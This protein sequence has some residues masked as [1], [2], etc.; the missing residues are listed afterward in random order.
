MSNDTAGPK[1]TRRR[2]FKLFVRG[3][4]MSC[5]AT[6]GGLAYATTIEP[7]RIRNREVAIR[8][9]G[10]PAAFDSY[11]IAHISDIHMDTWMDAAR[12]LAIA[13][14]VNAVG[15]DAIVI[16]G[17]FVSI[18]QRAKDG[19]GRHV[20]DVLTK[21]APGLREGLQLLKANDGV[22]A[23]PGNHDH[24]TDIEAVN[25]II[26]ASGVTL[27]TNG[28]APIRRGNERLWLCGVDDVWAGKPDLPGV[29]AQ[30]K[31]EA[32]EGELAI[33]LAHEPDSADDTA[34]TSRFALQ[35]SGH[36][37]GGQVA[38]PFVGPMVLPPFGRKYHTGLYRV[39]AGSQQMWQFT[40]RGVGMVEPRVRFNCPPEIAVL[41]LSREN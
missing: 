9:K 3:G 37:H 31:R 26:K 30:L 11:R 25:T 24:W 28:V 23:V 29:V 5:V 7:G 13:E 39:G 20:G 19:Q 18:D 32:K 33:L 34:A 15:A 4:V 6:G 1:M 8:L 17:D 10:L 12:F 2:F 16:T 38:L 41:T 21:F 22:F 27:L 14:R 40:T 36:S 35:L